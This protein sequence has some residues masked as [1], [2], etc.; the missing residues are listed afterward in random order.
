M[1]AGEKKSA[2]TDRRKFLAGAG[3]ALTFGAVT[4]FTG[5]ARSAETKPAENP[6]A[7]RIEHNSS[8]CAGCG[9]CG[10]MCSLY[11]EKETRV[12]LSRSVLDREPFEGAY[13][14]NVCRQCQAP[15]CYQSCPLKDS[16]LCID[17]ITGIKYIN[18]E[19]CD[20]CGKCTQAC[21]QKPAR[22][23]LN[24]DR[25]V[26]FKCDLCREREKGP[27]CIEYCSQHALAIVPGNRGI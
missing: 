6:I 16:A 15:S 12:I 10:L 9:V 19:K 21:P 3:A 27:I 4:G 23:K 20:G 11:H 22:I 18:A 5:Y 8:Q 25:K 26:A 7:G 17:K 24:A 1:A 14:L 2:V 13:A